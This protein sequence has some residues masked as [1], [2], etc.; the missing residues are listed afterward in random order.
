MSILRF[1]K[2]DMQKWG[3]GSLRRYI[4]VGEEWKY[5]LPE[6]FPKR[7]LMWEFLVGCLAGK[8]SQKG[9]YSHLIDSVNK[10]DIAGLYNL[11]D[12]EEPSLQ[13]W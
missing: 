1:T 12:I 13:R 11:Y 7:V 10:Y 4:I 5:E 3:G 9:P 2:R 8:N 6:V